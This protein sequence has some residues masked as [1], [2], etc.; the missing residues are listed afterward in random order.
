[1]LEVTLE[2]ELVCLHHHN[3]WL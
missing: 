2:N 1:M 3:G